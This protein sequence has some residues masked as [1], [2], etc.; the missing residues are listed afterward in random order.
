MRTSHYTYPVRLHEEQCRWLETMIHLSSTP[1]KHYLVARVLLM[2]DQRQGEPSSTNGQIAEALSISRR[3]V[4]RMKQRF[5][6]E[7]LEVALTGNFPREREGSEHA[8]VVPQRSGA[9]ERGWPRT[10]CM[11]RPP[12]GLSHWYTA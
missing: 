10:G 7:N 3:T 1:A 2:S 12:G 4:I 11:W 5:V 8:A 6:Q 9:T